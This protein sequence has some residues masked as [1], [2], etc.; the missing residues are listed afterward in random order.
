MIRSGHGRIGVLIVAAISQAVKYQLVLLILGLNFLGWGV[1]CL[2][3]ARVYGVPWFF[4]SDAFTSACVGALFVVY[5][6]QA[7]SKSGSIQ[8]GRT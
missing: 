2:A 1:F 4:Y 7:M 3:L 8:P 5:R 6:S